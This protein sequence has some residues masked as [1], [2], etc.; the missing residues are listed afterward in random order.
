MMNSIDNVLIF[1]NTEGMQRKIT[2][3]EV[4]VRSKY[5]AQVVLDGSSFTMGI[6]FFLNLVL[7]AIA[8]Y[9]ICRFY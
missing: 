8:M 9:Y 1:E 7:L 4:M 5:G 6:I 3:K 2:N